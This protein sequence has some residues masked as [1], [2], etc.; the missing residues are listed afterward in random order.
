VNRL[1]RLW[2]DYWFRPAPLANLAMTRIV[3]AGTQV[4]ILL[5]FT[6]LKD[7]RKLAEFPDSLYWPLPAARLALLPFGW[8]YRPPVEAL[9]AVFW[10]TLAAAVCSLIGLFTNLALAA[11]TLGAAFMQAYTYSFGELHHPEGLMVIA[12]GA[13]T[14]SPS[15]RVLSVD[16]LLRG[17]RDHPADWHAEARWPLLLAHWMFAF[18]YLSAA[19]YKWRTAGLDWANGY[20]LQWYILQDAL[21]WDNPLA[22]WLAQNH[23]MNVAMSWLTLLFESTFFLT[24]V[25]PRW[26][27]VY[28]PLGFAFHVGVYA[29]QKAGFFEWM[30]LYAVFVPW[31]GV[32]RRLARSGRG[33]AA[34]G[35]PA[36]S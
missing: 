6:F 31:L 35:Q 8:N 4:W 27:V 23:V 17:R 21:K 18:A 36:A 26:L 22:F 30:V 11:L 32:G 25:F 1:A 5:H 20:T 9:D 24:L 33:G 34:A 12:L 16:W 15:G 10:V 14:L 19:Y 13:L 7:F 3:L 29:F 2:A 28:A